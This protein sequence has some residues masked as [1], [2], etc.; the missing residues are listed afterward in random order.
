ML[1]TKS[2][3]EP[4]QVTVR[5]LSECYKRKGIQDKK[6]KNFKQPA[7]TVTYREFDA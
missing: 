5:K 2:L 3:A 7:E 1:I 4:S 6:A